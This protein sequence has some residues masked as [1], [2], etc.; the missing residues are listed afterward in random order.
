MEVV[1]E[2][3]P[4]GGAEE[5]NKP[6]AEAVVVVVELV[7]GLA[8]LQRR[9]GCSMLPRVPAASDPLCAGS[10]S[11]WGSAVMGQARMAMTGRCGATWFP[12]QHSLSGMQ[13]QPKK[14]VP[15]RQAYC[16]HRMDWVGSYAPTTASRRLSY[17]WTQ[18]SSPGAC[19]F[20]I[21][22]IG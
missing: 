20:K 13:Q 15:M 1:L 5:H 11:A 10:G 16:S 17:V 7:R 21:C 2:A 18:T 19:S 4:W 22:L 12:G 14:H 3:R 9:P 6:L 8:A